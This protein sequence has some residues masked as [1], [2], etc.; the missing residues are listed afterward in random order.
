[1]PLKITTGYPSVPL[2]RTTLRYLFT[3]LFQKLFTALQ[4]YY[5][6]KIE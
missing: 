2:I 6:S 1:M 3:P 4:M 5:N